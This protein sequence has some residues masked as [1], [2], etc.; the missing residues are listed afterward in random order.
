MMQKGDSYIRLFSALSTV[1]L[2]DEFCHS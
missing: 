1:R 2:L